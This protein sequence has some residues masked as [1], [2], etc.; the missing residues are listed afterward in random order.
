MRSASLDLCIKSFA[1]R[2]TTKYIYNLL[3]IFAIILIYIIFNIYLF[4]AMLL[5]HMQK[6][7][8][9]CQ[10]VMVYWLLHHL[11]KERYKLLHIWRMWVV[12]KISQWC[13]CPRTKHGNC[14][15]SLFRMVLC[16]LDTDDWSVKKKSFSLLFC[17]EEAV[18]NL[19]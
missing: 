12:M 5:L 19:F 18:Y 15:I 7:G 17:S 13:F 10:S 8:K 1:L 4:V 14:S 3:F 11:L 2:V 9:C 16:G 6:K